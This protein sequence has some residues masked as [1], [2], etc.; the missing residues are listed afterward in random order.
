M[1]T[2]WAVRLALGMAV[3][4]ALMAC[5]T[6]TRIESPA[7]SPESSNSKPTI[8]VHSLER[9]IHDLTNQERTAG[10]LKAL[11]FDEKLAT[12]A[13]GHSADMVRVEYFSHINK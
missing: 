8:D 1:R 13:R 5:T 6:T 9:Q 7:D 10:G 11:A 2:I 4:A 12:V 3:L